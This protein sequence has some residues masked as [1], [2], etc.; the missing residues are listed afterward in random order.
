MDQSI[1][2]V[3]GQ[4]IRALRKS[5]GY[6]LVTFAQALHRGKSVVSKYERGEVSIDITTLKQIADLLGV[7]LT[8]L[9]ADIGNPGTELFSSSELTSEGSPYEVLYMYMY[10]AHRGK[11]AI[12]RNVVHIS[13]NAASIYAELKDERH[14]EEYN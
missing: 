4:R 10:A 1:S 2:K 6:T 7:S 13:E 12:N 9:L 8:M 5:A 11:P 3:L 14:I